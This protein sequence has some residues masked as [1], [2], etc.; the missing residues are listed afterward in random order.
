MTIDISKIGVTS[1]RVALPPLELVSHADPALRRKTEVFD[2]GSSDLDPVDIAAALADLLVRRGGLGLSANQAGLPHRVCVVWGHPIHALFNPVI[3]GVS[4]ETA[5][6]EEGCLSYPNLVLA[7]R[8]PKTIRVRYQLPSGEWQARRFEG[9][10][11]RVLQ[12]EIDHLDGRVFFDR[13]SRAKLD[14]AIRRARKH[15]TPYTY[16]ELVGGK[17]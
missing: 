6:L 10:T 15:G 14:A 9:L 11:A 16:H 8:R 4:D 7:V 12:H 3:T 2:F 13:V 5:L 17:K 1:K